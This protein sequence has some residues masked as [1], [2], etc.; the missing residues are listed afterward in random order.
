[1][2]WFLWRKIRLGTKLGTLPAAPLEWVARV[3]LISDV[4]RIFHI[5]DETR[6]EFVT[7]EYAEPGVHSIVAIQLS[8]K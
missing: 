5:P 2:V 4:L 1:M 8:P 6:R 7:S 3:F